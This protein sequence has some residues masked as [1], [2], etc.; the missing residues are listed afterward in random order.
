MHKN[1]NPKKPQESICGHSLAGNRIYI[2]TGDAAVKV[3]VLR[4]NL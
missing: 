3:L 4:C 2:D 1:R